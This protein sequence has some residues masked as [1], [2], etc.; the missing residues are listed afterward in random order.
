MLKTS[1]RQ[2]YRKTKDITSKTPN[3]IIKEQRLTVVERLWVTTTN[4]SVDEIMHKTGFHNRGHF[5]KVFSQRFGTTP[6][7]YRELRKSDVL[8]L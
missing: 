5:F 4:L 3:E 6:K 1:V 8:P 7:S 2:L